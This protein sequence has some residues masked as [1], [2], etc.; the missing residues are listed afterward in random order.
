M[1]M[2][3]RR[4][5]RMRGEEWILRDAMAKERPLKED[6]VSV[7]PN[8]KAVGGYFVDR[9]AVQGCVNSAQYSITGVWHRQQQ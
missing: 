6:F 7:G 1:R 8:G 4:Q 9:S 3:V 2:F 5:V